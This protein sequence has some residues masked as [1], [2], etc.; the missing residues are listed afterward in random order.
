MEQGRAENSITQE[1]KAT[2]PAVEIAGS[3]GLAEQ[4]L[5]ERG[6]LKPYNS[7]FAI[8]TREKVYPGSMVLKFAR[9]GSQNSE[10]FLM[11]V[12]DGLLQAYNAIAVGNRR[13]TFDQ[14]YE[15]MDEFVEPAEER[16]KKLQQLT[17]NEGLMNV[18]VKRWSEVLEELFDT[19]TG[20]WYLVD[21]GLQLL[22]KE[23]YTNEKFENKLRDIADQKIPNELRRAR[24]RKGQLPEAP[25][26]SFSNAFE[27]KLIESIATEDP[28]WANT[29]KGAREK[30]GRDFVDFAAASY[31]KEEIYLIWALAV[32]GRYPIKVG[33]QWERP[34]DQLT[35]DLIKSGKPVKVEGANFGAVY[36][37]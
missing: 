15:V 23:R 12:S 37:K 36:L 27:T 21:F 33:P 4:L 16:K 19:S 14:I 6:T 17:K 30:A 5:K 11:V 28:Q 29:L 31:V 26:M 13:L 20:Q 1:P 8:S 25:I 18:K 10:D 7:W 34:Y 35:L 2:E 9:W 3:I 22:D 32:T 24:K